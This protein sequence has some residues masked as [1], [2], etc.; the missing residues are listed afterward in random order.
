MV[1]SSSVEG[2]VADDPKTLVSP[3]EEPSP[4]VSL[5]T[6]MSQSVDGVAQ[7]I[8][9]VAL[10]LSTPL[11]PGTVNGWSL[12]HP[13]SSVSESAH[14]RASGPAVPLNST[15]SDGLPLGTSV[16][17][18]RGSTRGRVEGLTCQSYLPL[19]GTCS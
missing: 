14:G 18:S 13:G 5:K 3:S 10:P 2:P 16:S 11:P 17:G 9:T 12:K 1:V 19:L 15:G 4:S 8:R 6:F 7:A